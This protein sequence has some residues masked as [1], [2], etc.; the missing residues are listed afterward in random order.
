[1][2]YYIYNIIQGFKN[3]YYYL[4]IIWYDRDDDFCYTQELLLKKLKKQYKFLQK[5]L[6]TDYKK[7]LQALRICILILERDL[8]YYYCNFYFDRI[9]TDK[10]NSEKYANECLM[11]EKR[12]MKWFSNI[13]SKHFYSW[14]N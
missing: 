7:Q 12:D 4:P 11:L 9:K 6:H 10:N 1:M 2:N 3:L 13:Y 8:N 5:E 14:W